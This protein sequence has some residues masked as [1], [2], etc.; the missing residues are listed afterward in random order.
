MTNPPD[1]P[2]R[3]LGALVLGCAIFSLSFAGYAAWD[4]DWTT[5]EHVHLDWSERFWNTGELERDSAGRYAS[6][7]PIHV[8][9]VAL[10]QFVERRGSEDERT[11]R[12]AA[13]LPQVAWLAATL[14]AAF[15]LGGRLGGR[16]AA[17]LSLL[18]A[19]LEPNLIAHASV[20]TTDIALAGST[21][22]A[23]WA[24]IAQR[25]QPARW[26]AA[27]TGLFIGLALVAKFSAV[28][29]AP[30]ALGAA[31]LRT[32]A[33]PRQVAGHLA[34]CLG[35]AWFAVVG[36]YGGARVFEPLGSSAWKSGAFQ[37][38]AQAAPKLPV[39]LPMSFLE[40]VDR[41]RAR[42]ASE[43]PVVAIL[44]K[45]SPRPLWYYF[46]AA[47]SLKTPIALILLS[48][49]FGPWLIMNA[50]SRPEIAWLLA[51]QAIA[52]MFFS[53]AFRTQLGFRYTLMLVPVSCALVAFAVSQTFS[54]RGLTLLALIAASASLAETSRYWGDPLAFSSVLV[55]PKEKAYLFLANA[56]I[57]WNQNRDRWLGLAKAAGLPDNGALNPVD[58]APGLNVVS[59]SRMAGVFPGDRFR[60]AR[61]N[62]EPRAL[63]GWTHHFFD[64]TSEQYDRFL[65]EARR[66]QP[67]PRAGDLCGLSADG[68][69]DPP[70]PETPFESATAPSGP[71]VSVLCVA[72]RKGADLAAR[73]EEGRFNLIPSVRPD[74]ETYLT[75]GDRVQFRLDP[76]VHTFA[77]VETPYRRSSL[78]YKLN[79]RF[80]AMQHGALLRV[81]QVQPGQ[82]PL[83][84]ALLTRDR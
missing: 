10:R 21:A 43:A 16:A 23:L 35:C 57:D 80:A 19:S 54:R 20:A 37:A 58:L 66:L 71:R 31:F 38:I 81:I 68:A 52:L 25:Q 62:L 9:N 59:T 22:L 45:V 64:V 79:A 67:T 76:G 7:T 36:A 32:G 75:P 72:T 17:L 49:A 46:L 29:L 4:Q 14:L 24:A 44:G 12:F 60:W 13:R 42:D 84:L 55:Q 33:R 39:P 6:T 3:A 5:D 41:S 65:A 48:L 73:V 30:L 77:I 53:F 51:H 15:A 34:V 50:R 74:L 2:A 27:A 18:F 63:A 83:D 69:M 28:L 47:W 82:M 61:E 1:F 78:P 11:R 56:D 70:G 8:P 40:G 26:R